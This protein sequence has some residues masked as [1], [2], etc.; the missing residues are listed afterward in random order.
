[1]TWTQITDTYRADLLTVTTEMTD[2]ERVRTVALDV[3][4][5][6]YSNTAGT[7]G[8]VSRLALTTMVL[9]GLGLD[10][11]DMELLVE[12][13]W[14]AEVDGGWQRDWSDQESKEKVTA[15][16]QKRAEYS[17]NWR[18]RS[19]RCAGGDHSLCDRCWAV[20]TGWKTG[21]PPMR[22]QSREQSRNGS[23]EQSRMHSLPS[24]SQPSPARVVTR[25]GESG[26]GASAEPPPSLAK[27]RSVVVSPPQEKPDDWLIP[28]DGAGYRE[29]E[30]RMSVLFNAWAAD[31]SASVQR[32]PRK[33][34]L[35]A[36]RDAGGYEAFKESERQMMREAGGREMWLASQKKGK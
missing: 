4:A 25:D 8:Y 11:C 20:K 12:T 6:A 17:A 36:W 9:P 26:D 5:T 10:Q 22:E 29:Q 1:M 30:A 27:A 35:F 15:R 24:P 19:K 7:D 18:E 21:D 33:G 28:S 3:M 2:E 32:L 23:R 14:W 31:Q 16:R 13:G 34:R